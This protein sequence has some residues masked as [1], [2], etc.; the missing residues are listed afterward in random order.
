M[1]IFL[2]FPPEM[3]K[4][5]KLITP[6]AGVKSLIAHMVLTNAFADVAAVL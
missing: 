5:A 6:S 2:I 4:V 1:I 3:Y